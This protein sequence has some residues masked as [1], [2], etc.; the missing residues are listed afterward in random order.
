[1]KYTM[2]FQSI[3]LPSALIFSCPA[4]HRYLHSFPT[5]RS[6]DLAFAGNVTPGDTPG[7]PVTISQPG[8][9][10]L[11]GNL[12]VPDANTT[13]ISVTDNNI[14]IDSQGFSILGLTTGVGVPVTSCSPAGN[15]QGVSSSQ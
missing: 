4:D 15:G 14:T 9:Y 13:A 6:S 3:Q 5:R 10:R 2:H 8:S 11:S 12:T 1:M 7:F